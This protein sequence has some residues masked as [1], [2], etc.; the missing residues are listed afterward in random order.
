MDESQHEVNNTSGIENHKSHLNTIGR[1]NIYSIK[2]TC[3]GD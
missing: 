3:I 2:E 1:L